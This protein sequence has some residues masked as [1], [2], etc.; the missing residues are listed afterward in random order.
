MRPR[1]PAFIWD[2]QQAANL[3]IEKTRG[4]S[5]NE[6]SSDVMLKSAI[7]R[8]VEIAGEAARRLADYDRETASQLPGLRSAIGIRSVI[9]HQ[10]DRINWTKVREFIDGPQTQLHEAVSQLLDEI[11]PPGM[12]RPE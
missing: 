3:V 9:A 6:I 12:K 10:Y 4:L 7:E 11:G 2:I 8:Q 5:P 1:T